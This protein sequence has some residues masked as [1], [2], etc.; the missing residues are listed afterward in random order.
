V[1]VNVHLWLAVEANGLIWPKEGQIIPDDS[2]SWTATVFEDGATDLF[3]LSLLVA[4]RRA[5]RN[6]EAWL[7]SGKRSGMYAELTSLRGTRRVARVD[8]LRLS[9]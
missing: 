5:H 1:G 7:D 3:S 9:S 8:D 4:D 2:G 6:I